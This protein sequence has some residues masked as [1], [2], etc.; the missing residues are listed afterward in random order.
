MSKDQCQST[1]WALKGSDDALKGYEQSMIDKY[2]NACAKSDS[3]IDR[4]AYSTGYATGL[5][6]FCTP[7]YA[8]EYGA[9]GEPY[10]NTCAEEFEAGF[11]QA[12]RPAF[13][14][15]AD[16]ESERFEEN[17]IRD[18]E[19]S[20]VVSRSVAELLVKSNKRT[21]TS[22]NSCGSGGKC[23]STELC[24]GSWCETVD[25]CNY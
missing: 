6:K 12:Y 10:R 22:N 15:N 13:A 16:A 19:R 11:L 23:E 14:R 9:R 7:N 5:Q 24:D 8:A 20:S 3:K 21:C 17:R 1:D 18:T 2:E 4:P 25:V